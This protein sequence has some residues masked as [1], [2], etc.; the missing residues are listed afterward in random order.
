MNLRAVMIELDAKSLVD[1]LNKS[2]YYNS[3]ISPLLDDCSPLLDDCKLLIS[4]IPQVH[5]KHTYRKANKCAD[6]LANLGLIQ[7]LDFIVHSS[8]PLDL[9]PLVEVDSL[10]SFCNR[11]CPDLA[12]FS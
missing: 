8:L 1:T 10:G 5:V 4:Q 2:S 11:L 7:T 6:L 9:I 12:S 3:V